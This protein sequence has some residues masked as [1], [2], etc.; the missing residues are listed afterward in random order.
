MGRWMDMITI[1]VVPIGA[2]L[3]AIM[4]YWVLGKENIAK[5]LN[6]GRQKPLKDS[7]FWIAKYFYVFLAAIVVILSIVYG[8]IG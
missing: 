4:I 3:G 5:E 6:L 8:G 2:V 7:F 1:Y